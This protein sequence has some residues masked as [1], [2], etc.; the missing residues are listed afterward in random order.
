MARETVDRYLRERIPQADAVGALNRQ[1]EPYGLAYRRVAVLFAATTA[2]DETAA[3][4]P[5][6]DPEV[7]VLGVGLAQGDHPEIGHTAI[8]GVIVLGWPR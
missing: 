6:L 7:R 5:L 4:E 3:M 1:L 8:V 2:I